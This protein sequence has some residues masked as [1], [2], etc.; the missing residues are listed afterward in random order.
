MAI[1]GQDED[2]LSERLEQV[3]VELIYGHGMRG[4]SSCG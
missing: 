4:L 1:S 2:A 3:M